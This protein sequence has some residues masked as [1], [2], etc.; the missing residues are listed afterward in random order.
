MYS[1]RIS[2]TTLDFNNVEVNKKEFHTFKQPIA[3]DLVSLDQILIPDK[4]KHSDTGF[5]YF[6]GY[7][8]GNIIRPLCIILPQMS[9]FLKYFDNGGKNVTFH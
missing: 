6:I 7:K 8:D 9:G 3:L 1:I 2:K 4:F 5:K